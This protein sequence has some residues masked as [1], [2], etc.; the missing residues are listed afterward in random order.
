MAVGEGFEVVDALADGNVEG[1]GMALGCG[2][3]LAVGFIGVLGLTEGDGGA[4][5]D[6][7][8]ADGLGG[9]GE[10]DGWFPGGK[11][12]GRRETSGARI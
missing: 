5:R 12:P 11:S 7:A 4:G 10:G 8:M 3:G 6:G 2:G 1:V 9:S